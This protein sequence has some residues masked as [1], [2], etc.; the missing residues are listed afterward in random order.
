MVRVIS[1]TVALMS[2]AVCSAA[3]V[4]FADLY[5]T[6]AR[7]S[8]TKVTV[9]GLVEVDGDYIYVWP[10]AA[11]CKRQDFKRSIFVVQDL[12]KDPYPGTNLSPYSPANLHWAKVTG[13]VNMSYHGLFGDLPFGLRL[14]KIEVLPGPRLK[15]LLPVLVYL[16]N[17][18][19]KNVELQLKAGALSEGCTVSPNEVYETAIPRDRWKV[20]ASFGGRPFLSSFVGRLSGAYYD[21][22][23][24]AFYYR[25]TPRSIDPVIPQDTRRWKFAPSPERD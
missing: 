1:I 24:R 3:E 13:T 12:R 19:G 25:I 15:D 5:K 17:E 22:E 2:A 9:R 10:D 4:Q 20:V 23:R 8:G 18:T 11:T 7:F 21:H 14:G 16:H 6:P